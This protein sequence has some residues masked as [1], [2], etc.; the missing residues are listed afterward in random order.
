ML[1]CVVR[2][3][4]PRWLLT[5]TPYKSLRSH[6]G[7]MIAHEICSPLF[8]L[9]LTFRT[10]HCLPLTTTGDKYNTCMA[11]VRRGLLWLTLSLATL[12]AAISPFRKYPTLPKYTFLA[13]TFDGTGEWTMIIYE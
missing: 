7:S 13:W 12:L 11:R 5:A 9:L 2:T 1:V 10:V 3:V 4:N 8:L 6:E